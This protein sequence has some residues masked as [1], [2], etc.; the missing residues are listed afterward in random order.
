MPI[1]FK[2]PKQYIGL[3]IIYIPQLIII[4]LKNIELT[5]THHNDLIQLVKL[6]YPEYFKSKNTTTSTILWDL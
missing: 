3:Q 5:H 2:A 1:N 4:L 6:A